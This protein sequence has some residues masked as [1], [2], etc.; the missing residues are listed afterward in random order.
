MIRLTDP[1]HTWRRAF[2]N[3][4][5]QALALA[6]HRSIKVT[7]AA[8]AQWVNFLQRIKGAAK[9]PRMCKWSKVF[10]AL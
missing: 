8:A 5:K 2:T 10:S 4:T 3:I 1:S 7:I 6:L 9:R